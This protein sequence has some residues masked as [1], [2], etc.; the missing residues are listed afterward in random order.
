MSTKGAEP[1][2]PGDVASKMA[3]GSKASKGTEVEE[4]SSEDDVVEMSYR[5]VVVSG[6]QQSH[7]FR[8]IRSWLNYNVD[9]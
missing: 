7:S 1:D 9:S 8:S 6:R 5:D 4:V 2:E 3:T